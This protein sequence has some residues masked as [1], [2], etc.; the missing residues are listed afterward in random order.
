MRHAGRRRGRGDGRESKCGSSCASAGLA[1][2]SPLLP[3]A[4]GCGASRGRVGFSPLFWGIVALLQ[5]HPAGLTPAEMRTLLGVDR[6]LADTCL[7][8]QRVERGR[9]V[10][11]E[12]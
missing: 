3:Q 1:G 12:R 9:Y 11:A 8:M 2:V 5:D 6:P 10:A 4:G 7:G